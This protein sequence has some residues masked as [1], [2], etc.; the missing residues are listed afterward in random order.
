MLRWTRKLG[1]KL[2]EGQEEE[3]KT[4]NARMLEMALTCHGTFNIDPHHLPYLLKSDKDI[5]VV[6]ECS[7]IVHDR[8][9]AATDNLPALIK[10]LLRQYWRLLHTLEPLLHERILEVRNGLDST[11]SQLWAGYAPGSPWMALETPSERWLVTE[12]SSEGG[13]SSILVYYNLLDRSLLVNR[14]PLT[15]L[16]RSYESHPTFC[17]LFGEVVYPIHL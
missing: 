16:P 8:C 13:L 3:L 2:Q 17:R 5:A 14:S 7:I 9:P 15:R 6:A 10:T 1:Q 11:V 12:T 4:L